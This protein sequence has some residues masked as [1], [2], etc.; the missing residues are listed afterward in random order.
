MDILM[1][2]LVKELKKTYLGKYGGGGENP[3]GKKLSILKVL[4]GQK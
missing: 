3:I 4:L 1:D 2:K